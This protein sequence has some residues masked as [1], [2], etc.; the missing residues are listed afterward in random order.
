MKTNLWFLTVL[1]FFSLLGST[2]AS[3]QAISGDLVGAVTDATGAAVPNATIT[4][5]NQATNIK[6][7][8]TTNSVGEY[9]IGNLLPGKY[10]VSA[11]A[12]GFGTS[13]LKDVIVNLNSTITANISLQVGTLATSVEVSEASVVLDTTTAQVQNSYT[14]QQA[15]DIPSASI[16]QGVLN[17]SLLQAGVASSGGVGYGSGPSIGGQRPT[18]NNFTI[19]GVDNNSKS[20]TGPTV[21]IPNDDVAEFTLLQNQFRAEYGHSSGGQFNSIV[22]SGGNAYHGMLYDYLQNRKLNA[23]DQTYANIGVYSNPRYDQNRLGI[24]TG[25]PIIKN[26]FF[27]FA[28]FEYNPTG[29]ASSSSS[30]FYAPTSAGYTA[31]AAAPGV[32]QTNLNLLK[33]YAM[34]SAPNSAGPT[35]T[36]GSVS[37]PTGII[38]VVGPNFNNNFNGVASSDYNISDRDQLRG[39]FVYNRGDGLDTSANLP[40]FWTGVPSREYLATLAEYHTFSPSVVNELRLGFNRQNAFYPVGNQTFPGLDAFPNL[41]FSD[42]NLQV[43]PDGSLPQGGISNLYQ[44]SDAITYTRGKHTFK[45]GYE[46]RDYIAST[47]FTQR[48]RGDYEYSTLA[49]YLTDQYPDLVNNRSIGNPIFY[50]NQLANYFFVQDTWRATPRLTV[51][52]GLRYEYTGVPVGARQQSLNAIASTSLLNFRSPKSDSTGYGPRVGIAYTPGTSGNTVIRAGFSRATDIIYDNLPLNS[53]PPQFTTAVSLNGLTGNNFLANG[54][55]NPAIYQP[56]VLSAATARTRTANYLADQTLPYSLNWTL[57]VE[58]IIAKN[59]TFEARYTGTRGIHELLQQQIDRLHPTVNATTNIPVYLTAPSAATLASLPY[60]VG[61]LRPSG[62]NGNVS[63]TGVFIDPQYIA[64]GYAGAITSYQPQGWSTYHGLSL[65]M[66]RRFSNGLQFL[67]AY[68]WSHN[69]DNS[70]STLNTSALTQRRAQDFGNLTPEKASSALD[71]RHRLTFSAIYDL[72]FYKSSNN[73]L[74]KNVVGNW[75]LA[76]VYTYESPEYF[77]VSSNVNGNFNGDSGAI[78]RSII[79]PAGAAGVASTVYGLDRSGNVIKY[80]AAA[81]SVNNVVAWVANNPNA[82]YIQAAAGAFA[83]A[84]RNTEPTRPINNIDMSLV[85]KFNITERM[86]MQLFGQALNMLNHPQF[87]PGSINDVARVGTAGST[88]F[89]ALTNGN[90]NNPER[91]FA[92]NART[93]QV[94]AKFIF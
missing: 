6:A 13:T 75:E 19:E 68:T 5:T 28:G 34:A 47:S 33:Q 31:L 71:R 25:G 15:Q 93:L 63:S 27:F 50:G 64:A 46:F 18:N 20:V 81:S 17:L 59:Y 9:R 51:D 21:F 72:P 49:L 55:I 37:V 38:S 87:I 41:Y 43:G 80:N 52:L 48:V 16:G 36:I 69:I 73:W 14:T 39:R 32:S 91:A 82:R 56:G 4:A 66:Q 35:I 77:T 1:V 90:F 54:G 24:N 57:A 74:M 30:V 78:Y 42:L 53:P 84:G 22:K 88:A 44:I 40:V 26:K 76:P 67:G 89:S 62:A 65:Q 10:S 7:T 60:T 61:N 94:T 29:R 86:Q 12:P 83:N 8:A 85:K 45:V 2:T 58:R 79:N 23:V 92:S 3:A 70:T 11:S